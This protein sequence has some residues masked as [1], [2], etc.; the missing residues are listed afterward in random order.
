[1]SEVPDCLEVD[2][3]G[4]STKNPTISDVVAPSD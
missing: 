3:D 1:M 4:V 2:R